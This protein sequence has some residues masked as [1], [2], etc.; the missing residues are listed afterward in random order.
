MKGRVQK[1]GTEGARLFRRAPPQGVLAQVV[2]DLLSQ[3]EDELPLEP[4]YR[5]VELRGLKARLQR[6]FPH[7]H[8]LKASDSDIA[9]SV[10]EEDGEALAD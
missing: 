4:D 1:Q 5:R 7:V 8:G 3:L 9:Q 2:Y 10:A 6:A